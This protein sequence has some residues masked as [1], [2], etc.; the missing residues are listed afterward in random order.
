MIRS[1]FETKLT[2]EIAEGKK[3]PER[4]DVNR[5][6]LERSARKALWEKRNAKPDA[7]AGS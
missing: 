5:R 4:S 7:N 2:R 6:A 3:D 1:P